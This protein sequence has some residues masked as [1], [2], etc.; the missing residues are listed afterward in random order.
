GRWPSYSS[1]GPLS[2]HLRFVNRKARKLAREI[3]HGMSVY[4][5]RMQNKQGFL[6]RV[7]DIANELFAMAAVVSQAEALR[8]T[9][10]PSASRASELA[11]LFCRN[12]RRDVRRLFRLL[13]RND[14]ALKYRLGVKVLQGEHLWM[15]AGAMGVETMLAAAAR[16]LVVDAA[17]NAAVTSDS[18]SA[19]A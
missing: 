18:S 12:S 16:E 10:D 19:I 3:F 14:D 2:G 6:F 13:W 11:D 9:G 1:F 17:G 7:V 5:G 15:E 4:Q 8:R